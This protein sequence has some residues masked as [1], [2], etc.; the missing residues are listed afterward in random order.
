MEDLRS[1]LPGIENH[2]RR[3]MGIV[4]AGNAVFGNSTVMTLARYN[5]DGTLDSTFGSG[6]E[7]VSRI[8]ANW[9]NA[10]ALYPSTDTTGNAKKIVEAGGGSWPASMPTGA[11]TLRSAAADWWR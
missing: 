4:V 11:P 9:L 1:G 3:V 5:T 2:H 6:G 7:F 10:A 8:S